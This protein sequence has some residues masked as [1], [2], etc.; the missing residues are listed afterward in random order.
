MGWWRGGL[1]PSTLSDVG[2]G[3]GTA[4]LEHHMWAPE[5]CG[6][7]QTFLR[8]MKKINFLF[9]KGLS[10][11]Q[12]WAGNIL[13]KGRH[14]SSQARSRPAVRKMKGAGLQFRS[15]ASSTALLIC[16]LWTHADELICVY[17]LS[18]SSHAKLL[19][20]GTHQP[21]QDVLLPCLHACGC[22]PL[23]S[24]ERERAM[25]EEEVAVTLTKMPR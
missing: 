6:H 3:R 16:S 25:P 21:K 9:L 1:C 24:Q 20:H 22:V 15:E 4:W 23:C 10:F 19:R 18:E 2:R 17:S 13:E 12:M 8:R 5:L 11:C 7:W 14:G